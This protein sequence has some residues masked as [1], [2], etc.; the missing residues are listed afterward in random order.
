MH[1]IIRGANILCIIFNMHY[2]EIRG[3]ENAIETSEDS[4]FLSEIHSYIY[5][6]VFGHREHW[7]WSACY[8]IFTSLQIST[9]ISF[10]EMTAMQ[11]VWNSGI[12]TVQNK[13]INWFW[14][15]DL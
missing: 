4:Q 1:Y 7:A 6:L 9:H 14:F 13:T 3:D 11:F 12:E 2:M 5:L 15:I 10:R 8:S